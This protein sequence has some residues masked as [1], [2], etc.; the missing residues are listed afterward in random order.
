MKGNIK[1]IVSKNARKVLRGVAPIGLA[2]GIGLGANEYQANIKAREAQK[3]EYVLAL[4]KQKLSPT[5]LELALKL[6]LNPKFPFDII[7]IKT[8]ESISS[9]TRVPQLE[10][11]KTIRKNIDSING[12]TFVIPQKTN[13]VTK[14]V[15]EEFNALSRSDQINLINLSKRIK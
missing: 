13:L 8:I 4:K 12:T 11:V 9:K 6:K 14:K 5:S 2:F 1:K 10:V 15:M 3:N 7:T